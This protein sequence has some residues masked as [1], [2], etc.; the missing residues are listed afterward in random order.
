MN[1]VEQRPRA[2]ED[3]ASG[4]DITITLMMPVLNEID[5]L[6]AV[7]PF[8]DKTLFKEILMIDGGSTDGSVEFA[9][10]HGVTV[11]RQ[12]QAGLG[13]AILEGYE[14]VKTSHMIEFSPDGN[15]R[16]EDI[17]ALVEKLNMGYDL[18]VVSRYLPPARSY[19][20]TFITA[21]GNWLFSHLMWGL[22]R[23]KP[24]DALTIFRGYRLETVLPLEALRYNRGPVTEP[25]T[26]AWACLNNR[27]I[28]EIPGDE[29]ARIG[30]ASKMRVIYNG[31]CILAMIMRLYLL[32]LG[33]RT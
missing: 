26:T 31:L 33:I 27:L 28:C 20:D 3:V 24:T 6:R 12:R 13:K 29:P 4:D 16:P 32:R 30:G 23:Y 25:L 21:L 5:G 17:P 19:D 8:I 11:H 15:C 2:G 10:E 7:L 14:R 1:F 18:V 22:G 9:L